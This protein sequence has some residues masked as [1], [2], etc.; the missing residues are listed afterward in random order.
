[1]FIPDTAPTAT[2]PARIIIGCSRITKRNVTYYYII[3]INDMYLSITKENTLNFEV[4][5]TSY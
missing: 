4:P 3:Q 5:K 1:M 2:R